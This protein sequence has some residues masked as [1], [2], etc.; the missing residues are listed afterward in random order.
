[1]RRGGRGKA[2]V[3]VILDFRRGGLGYG[4]QRLGLDIIAGQCGVALCDK[5]RRH[6][7]IVPLFERLWVD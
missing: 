5:R 7:T 4:F 6:L 2:E 3:G 1:M